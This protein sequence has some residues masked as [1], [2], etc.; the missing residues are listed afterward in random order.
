MLNS[1]S[2]PTAVA[3]TLVASVVLQFFLHAWGQAASGVDYSYR[4]AQR[5]LSTSWVIMIAAA[6]FLVAAGIAHW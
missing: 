3:F 6:G 1:L 2:T 4:Y 5:S